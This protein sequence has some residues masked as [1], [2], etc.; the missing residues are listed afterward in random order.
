MLTVVPVRG[1]SHRRQRFCTR[2]MIEHAMPQ[3][4]KTRARVRKISTKSSNCHSPNPTTPSRLPAYRAPSASTQRLPT[5]PH[6]VRPASHQCSHRAQFAPTQSPPTRPHPVSQAFH[7]CS[8][9]ASIASRYSYISHIPKAMSQNRSMYHIDRI[10]RWRLELFHGRH[11]LYR[12]PGLWSI[13]CTSDKEP[14]LAIDYGISGTKR[15][16]ASALV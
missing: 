9:T 13:P 11:S 8:Y 6:P 7:Q 15:P 12:C 1:G 4:Q 10:S 14:G 3:L 2:D 5:R 16:F